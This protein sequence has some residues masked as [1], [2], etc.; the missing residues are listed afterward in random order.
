MDS[1]ACRFRRLRANSRLAL[2]LVRP[3]ALRP[4]PRGNALKA[5]LNLL[6]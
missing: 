2:C 4:G 3:I 1:F 5:R 6:V